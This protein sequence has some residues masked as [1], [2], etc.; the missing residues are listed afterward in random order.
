MIPLPVT[1]Q[2]FN[3][4]LLALKSYKQ[5]TSAARGISLAALNFL[6][7]SP[8]LCLWLDISYLKASPCITCFV[9]TVSLFTWHRLK[10]YL[11]IKWVRSKKKEKPGINAKHNKFSFR[12]NA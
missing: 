9:S 3:G 4:S 12:L 1:P 10:R 7:S 5:N 6:F 2:P 8:A 11:L